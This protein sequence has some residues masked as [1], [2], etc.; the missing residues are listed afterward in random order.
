MTRLKLLILLVV[1]PAACIL[2]PNQATAQFDRPTKE[3]TEVEMTMVLLD[4]ETI[5]DTSQSFSANVF[6]MARWQDPRLAHE[7]SQIRRYDLD[8][9]WSPRLQVVNRRQGSI[10]LPQ[11]VEV[12]QKGMVTYRQRAVGSFSQKL[13]LSNFPLDRQTFAIQLVAV[14]YNPDEISFVSNPDFPS[15][16][17]PELTIPDRTIQNARSQPRPYQPL[18][19][20]RPTAGHA[21]TFETT[22]KPGY[23]FWKI[24]FPLMLVVCMSLMVLWIDPE[25]AAPRVGIPVTSMLTVIAYRFMVVNMVPKI[26]Y[27]TRLDQFI[28]A[29]TVLVFLTLVESA[30]SVIATR[31][32]EKKKALTIDKTAS[33]ILTL[34]Y[35]LALAWAFF[36]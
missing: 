13:D 34:A 20:V 10:T 14:G 21:L 22:R 28:L 7:D 6:F 3:A 1:M 32:G 2:I 11:V 35:L 24:I 23:F 25:V 31:R 8:E 5:E 17:V 19:A 4:L 16:V 33:G 36:A 9:V 15:P 12:T 30:W 18:A 26:S 27:L 29:S